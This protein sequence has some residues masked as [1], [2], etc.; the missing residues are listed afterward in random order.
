M[1]AKEIADEL[2]KLR[3]SERNEI[4]AMFGGSEIYKEES[5]DEFMMEKRFAGGVFCPRCGLQHMAKN[6]RRANGRQTFLCMDCKRQFASTTGTILSG[7]PKRLSVW[8]KYVESLMNGDSL[9]KSA[10]IC[11]IDLTTAFYWR[12]K[13]LDALENMAGSVTL[14]GISE[15]DEKYFRISSYK[16]NR[17]RSR[18]KIPRKSRKRG[19]GAKRGL[20]DEQACVICAVNREGLSVSVVS[21]SGKP[22][23]VDIDRALGGRIGRDSILC[24][25]KMNSYKRF[26]E[27]NSLEL[28]QSKAAEGRSGIYNIQKVNSYHS[29]LDRFMTPYNGVSTKYLSHYLILNNIVNYAMETFLEKQNIFIDFVFTTRKAEKS[30]DVRKRPLLPW[31]A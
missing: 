6:G 29:G 24:T 23:S 4:I 18:Q 14:S 20:S 16:G 3:E 28:H 12:H 26:A 27:K 8:K 15:A 19:K 13:I 7:S 2:R 30:R 21:N 9:R 10:G 1:T 11:K 31:A 25:D 5:K 17:S 22:S